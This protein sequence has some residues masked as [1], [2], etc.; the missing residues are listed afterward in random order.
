MC[1]SDEELTVTVDELVLFGSALVQQKT[2]CYSHNA[3][4]DEIHSNGEKEIVP[5]NNMGICS[6]EQLYKGKGI[7][8]AV[9]RSAM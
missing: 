5:V 1:S 3:K 4:E 9:E 7:S 6:F 8:I 2:L